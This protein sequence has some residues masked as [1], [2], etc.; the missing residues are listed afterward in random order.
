MARGRAEGETA[1]G[2]E[3]VMLEPCPGECVRCMQLQVEALEWRKKLW[4]ARLYERCGWLKNIRFTS[5]DDHEARKHGRM[6]VEAAIGVS[7]SVPSVWCFSQVE[8]T[9]LGVGVPGVWTSG[10]RGVRVTMHVM[11]PR[12]RVYLR[13]GVRHGAECKSV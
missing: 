9:G 1:G 8:R 12:W 4:A 2:T 13:R 11:T 10:E 7:A 5:E 6:G 3:S